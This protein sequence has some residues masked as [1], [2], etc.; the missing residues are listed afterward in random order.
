MAVKW[1][2][3]QELVIRQRGTNILASAA[4]GS[5]K[6]AVLVEHIIRRV[7]DPDHPI[8]ID[9]LLVVTFTRAAAGEMKDRIGRALEEK[10]RENP[11]NVHLQRQG[12][13]LHHAQINTIHGFCTYVIQNYFHRIHLDPGYRI[14]EEGELKMLKARVLQDMLEEQYQLAS[15]EGG[16]QESAEEDAK[17]AGYVEEA[18]SA[19][20]L[21]KSMVSGDTEKQDS[22]DDLEKQTGMFRR[23]MDA[24]APGKS[25]SRA[26]DL[27]LKI[28]KFAMSDP[29]PR[30]WL[31]NAADACRID[32]AEKLSE[33]DWLQDIVR[34]A[35]MLVED[36]ASL[37]EQN[38]ADAGNAG[39]PL[40][41][42]SALESDLELA[43]KLESCRSYG[44]FYRV[45]KEN[46][47]A[48]LSSRKT[49]GED[50]VLREQVKNSRDQF[51]N[52][53]NSLRADCF[54]RSEEEILSELGR[55]KPYA[56]ELVRLTELFMDRFAEAKRQRNIADFSDL[57]HFALRILLE[58]QEDGTY[59]RT[60]AARELAE[61]YAEIITDEYQDSNYIQE[62]ILEAVSG[63]EE[64]R[65]DRF[66]VGDMKQS[67][68]GFRMA[69]PDLFLAKYMEY[70]LLSASS[71]SGNM[72]KAAGKNSKAAVGNSGAAGENSET[73]VENSGIADRM[74]SV[75]INLD[76]N[77]RS[78][79]EVLDCTNAIFHRLMI[80]ELGGI[81]YDDA[82]AL[83]YGADYPEGEDPDFPKA[84]LLLINKAAPEFEDDRSSE[85][86]ARA[87]ALAIAGRIRE[88]TAS[89]KV[90]DR[91][92]GAFRPLTYRDC[93]ILMRS[94]GR[95][96]DIF[97]S[98]L[99]DEGIPAYMTSKDGYFSALEVT[100]V[101]NYLNILDNPGQDIPLTAVLRSPIVGCTDAEL[102]ELRISDPEG[103][104]YQI[105]REYA[106]GGEKEQN[107]ALAAKLRAFLGQ[108]SD[109]RE[110]IPCTEVHE[111]IGQ[112]IEETGYG[113]YAAA[114]PAGAQREANL[115]MLVEK[116]VD[117]EKT[118]YHGLF[119]FIRYIERMKKYEVDYGEVNL[120]SEAENT[121]R[122][123]S[124]HKSKGLEF[125]VVFVA[126]L[127][128]HFNFKDAQSRVV[129]HAKYGIGME[130]V[131]PDRHTSCSSVMQAAIRKAIR[132]DTLGEE[133]R[134]L[135]VAMT[136]AKE[137]L[138]L[139][140]IVSDK[141]RI[142]ETMR[143]QEGTEIRTAPGETPEEAVRGQRI[144]L[145]KPLSYHRLVSAKCP[146]DWV[147]MAAPSGKVLTIREVRAEEM[148][149]RTMQSNV[150]ADRMVDAL[151]QMIR[152]D[153]V[154]DGQ[155]HDFLDRRENFRYPY[156]RAAELPAKMTVTEIKMRSMEVMEEE[157]GAEPFAEEPE[158]P[159]VPEFMR[160][161]GHRE[162][163]GAA[164]GTIYHHV[165]ECLDYLSVD[166]IFRREE[167]GGKS[168]GDPEL[169][170]EFAQNP[171][172][173]EG[174]A[175]EP[176]AQEEFAENPELKEG[177][178]EEPEAQ[179]GLAENPELEERLAEEIRR[180]VQDMET[181]GLLSEIDAA[182]VMPEDFVRFLTSGIGIRMRRAALE[183][184]LRREQP[185]VID[186]PAKDID[187]SWPEDENI[188]VQGTI[189]AY[190][191]EN[192]KYVIVDYKT[193]RVR[194]SDGRDL[195]EKYQK[196]LEYYSRALSGITGVEVA[197][198][199]IY[200]VALGREIRVSGY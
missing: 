136:R 149:D 179:E 59:R 83:H 127:G 70:P 195:V 31:R 60:D 121:V 13:L 115:K 186:I 194:T 98:T 32:T 46:N 191:S 42:I 144:Q 161:K 67:I 160:E 137:K 156:Q 43:E 120:F 40:G 169:Q 154:C 62:A 61:Q 56:E 142:E 143:L 20:S 117:Y 125:P 180:Q 63:T 114:M 15:G 175:E 135:Y 158:V 198:T 74:R 128:N 87:E 176:G 1:T 177:F 73:A 113:R 71:E 94:P 164:R 4:A 12:V 100:T 38:L 91:D 152:S 23:F 48:K 119:N 22:T 90:W 102:A 6:T 134:I 66:M 21:E 165:L 34:E 192:G 47:F 49:A 190:F 163:A 155:V 108:L 54:S 52:M 69:R 126:G 107:P 86:M 88:L 68:Y 139:T 30:Q 185:F 178:A 131:D 89:G 159:Y 122:I 14:A 118:S 97:V 84:E 96:G 25:D 92:A 58:K 75:R 95:W 123:I 16:A 33:T 27:I 28:S 129:L 26:E 167:T 8:N 24:Y 45:L 9:Q 109:F 57:E 168:S 10:L 7:T 5:G 130:M 72:Q 112:V 145:Q 3:D 172:L 193:D 77:F 82:Q 65:Y 141:D 41:Y 153:A 51:K 39:G 99:Q 188:L 189:D 11:E 50:P 170:E 17:R 200:S 105:V 110:R 133:I 199:D 181:R 85:A 79:R 183:G 162:A 166:R 197:E 173:K 171:E 151:R 103:S 80:P 150:E 111:L 18:D 104:M 147:M 174:F 81:R 187:N 2:A 101:L 157:K 35:G 138:I 132:R 93:V 182:C 37:A 53:I 146:L 36:A 184:V 124:V 140:G 78:R 76:R 116:A 19:D 196:Q 106:D 64:K 148:A 29:D 55:I 44:D